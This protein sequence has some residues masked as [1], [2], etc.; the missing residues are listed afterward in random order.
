MFSGRNMIKLH[1]R[2]NFFININSIWNVYAEL[3]TGLDYI[4]IRVTEMY[5][6]VSSIYAQHKC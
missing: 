6:C 2:L 5:C 3:D 4:N 1:L